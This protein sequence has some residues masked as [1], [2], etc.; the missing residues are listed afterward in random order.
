M[1]TFDA[2]LNRLYKQELEKIVM[3][4]ERYRVALNCEIEARKGKSGDD[5][6]RNTPSSTASQVQRS[7]S[8]ASRSGKQADNNGL[9]EADQGTIYE[10]ETILKRYLQQQQ[11]QSMAERL[12]QFQEQYLQQQQQQQ[13]HHKRCSVFG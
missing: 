4:Y 1:E 11:E 2:M 6:N 10:N 3:S 5:E 8:N 13:Q 9:F 7:N 12:K